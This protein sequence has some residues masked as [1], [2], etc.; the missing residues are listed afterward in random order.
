MVDSYRRATFITPTFKYPK[1]KKVD[2]DAQINFISTLRNE[3]KTRLTAK[4]IL[5]KNKP[6]EIRNLFVQWPDNDNKKQIETLKAVANIINMATVVVRDHVNLNVSNDLFHSTTKKNMP[7]RL[8]LIAAL[9][10]QGVGKQNAEDIINITIHEG[11]KEKHGW[12]GVIDNFHTKTAQILY[13]N[14]NRKINLLARNH[15]VPDRP[16]NVISHKTIHAYYQSEK[17]LYEYKYF[18]KEKKTQV[19]DLA[20]NIKRIYTTRPTQHL[21]NMIKN[22]VISAAQPISNVKKEIKHE[23]IVE[24]ERSNH[25][26][27]MGTHNSE[28]AHFQIKCTTS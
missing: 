28:E 2:D 10:A 21:D 24:E 12:F 7:N 11:S 9:E 1:D 6:N 27:G 3:S 20:S 14:I 13:D 19:N 18:P 4:N 23:N 17:K 8:E 15:N 26:M 25:D 22:K 5:T 16:A